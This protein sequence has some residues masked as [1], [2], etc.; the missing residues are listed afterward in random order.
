MKLASN[1]KA[2]S[3]RF[4]TSKSIRRTATIPYFFI[5]GC[6]FM[7]LISSVRWPFNNWRSSRLDR[8][9]QDTNI[10]LLSVVGYRRLVMGRVRTH[11]LLSGHLPIGV[12][13]FGLRRRLSAQFPSFSRFTAAEIL[14]TAFGL[15]D[16]QC[17]KSNINGRIP[18]RTLCVGYSDY[19]G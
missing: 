13:I 6:R 2:R 16:F 17:A 11:F 10:C 18:M 1:K 8:I 12:M 15:N 3:S 4:M 14:I 19:G 5:H 9:S 7:R